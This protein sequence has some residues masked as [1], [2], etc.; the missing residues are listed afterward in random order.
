MPE[1]RFDEVMRCTVSGT[2]L[3]TFDIDPRYLEVCEPGSVEVCGCVAQQPVNSH[4][5]A[6]G[7]K[8]RIRLAD[9][10]GTTIVVV[11]LTGV[12]KGFS[13]ERFPDR[14]EEQFVENEKFIN[15]AY[16]PASPA[17]DE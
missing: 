2:D 1:V 9:D 6:D 15:S 3:H 13:G 14:T 8:V 11:R 12:R 4:A 7:A 16:P 17:E 5:Y 10:V